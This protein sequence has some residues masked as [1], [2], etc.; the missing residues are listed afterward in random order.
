[1]NNEYELTDGSETDS[2]AEQ[3]DEAMGI[4]DDRIELLK[5]LRGHDEEEAKPQVY[6]GRWR[7]AAGNVKKLTDENHLKARADRQ[8]LYDAAKSAKVGSTIVC[9]WCEKQHEKTTY[10]K[11]FCS[12]QKTVKRGKMSCKDLF[13]N[14]ANAKRAAA[15]RAYG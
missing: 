12:S 9:P 11:V 2:M 3:T 15:G 10:H 14:R 6:R 7:T 13:W 1:M 5:L 4:R 8:A